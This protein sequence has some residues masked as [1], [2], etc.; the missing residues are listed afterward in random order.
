M[1]TRPVHYREF[2]AGPKGAGDG[3]GGLPTHSPVQV[4]NTGSE[5]EVYHFLMQIYCHTG[6]LEVPGAIGIQVYQSPF[7]DEGDDP[8]PAVVKIPDGAS[9]FSGPEE[10]RAPTLAEM[11]I[12]FREGLEDE[13][14]DWE[15]LD[16]YSEESAL[17]K[18]GGATPLDQVERKDLR[19]LGW[20]SGSPLGF[21][22][23][24]RQ[25]AFFL[26]T[27]TGEIETILV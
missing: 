3:V 23:A 19:F 24:D 10:V 7:I 6:R 12:S 25:A 13:N 21:N 14:E 27:D 5:S 1:R 20:L 26:R 4:P 11:R 15:R 9:P 2:S 18:L 16:E 17:S 8:T 22:F